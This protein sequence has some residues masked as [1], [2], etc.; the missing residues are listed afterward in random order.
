MC[1]EAV[2]DAAAGSAGSAAAGGAAAGNPFLPRDD[3]T[4][5]EVQPPATENGGRKPSHRWWARALVDQRGS[6]KNTKWAIADMRHRIRPSRIRRSGLHPGPFYGSTHAAAESKRGQ[7]VM[8]S[9]HAPRQKRP[10][11][12]SECFSGRSARVLAVAT[13]HRGRGSTAAKTKV[14]VCRSFVARVIAVRT[15]RPDCS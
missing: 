1:D 6:G 8:E 2:D 10:K 14:A 4:A 5:D 12:A 3:R 11:P 7:H 9:L 15:S 13:K